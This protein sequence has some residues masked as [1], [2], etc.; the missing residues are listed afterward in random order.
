MDNVS[1]YFADHFAE[2]SE[3]IFLIPWESII[4]TVIIILVTYFILKG[5]K[6]SIKKY[7]SEEVDAHLQ[8]SAYRLLQIIIGL[9]AI[10]GIA[11]AWGVELTG[12]LAGAGFLGLILGFAAQQTIGNV[13]A[14]MLMMFSRPFDI[15]D[16]VEVEDFSGIVKDISIIYTK[17]ETFDGEE[18]AIPNNLMSSSAVNNLSRRGKLR[19]RKTIGIDYESDPKKAKEIAEE[20]MKYHPETAK[21]PEPKAIINDLG[22]SSVNIEILFWIKDPVPKKRR[23]TLDDLISSIKKKYEEN[24]IGIPF[25]HRELIQHEDRGWSFKERREE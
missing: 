5:I 22:D 11:S 25:P 19:V 16:W 8:K 12:L 20:E 4:G 17:I 3:W 14:G 7:T 18:I 23:Q 2:L 24:G 13:I 21:N 1:N 10:F 9:I 6:K 15:N